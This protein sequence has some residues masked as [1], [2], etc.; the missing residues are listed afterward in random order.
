MNDVECGVTKGKSRMGG[1]Y[2][3]FGRRGTGGRRGVWQRCRN[4]NRR[5]CTD[6]GGFSE[7]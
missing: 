3:G 4:V 2:E 6:L 1:R 7:E 5:M